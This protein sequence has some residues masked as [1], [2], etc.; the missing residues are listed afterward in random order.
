M[1]VPLSI[2]LF[3]YLVYIIFFFVFTFFN[4]YHILKFGFASFG[5]YLIT[6][7]YIAVTILALFVSYFYVARIDWSA[8]VEMFGSAR[9]V[10]GLI[11]F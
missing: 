6:F 5:A 1:I 9:N 4:L 8:Q 3:I 2:F 10:E 7:G 11:G